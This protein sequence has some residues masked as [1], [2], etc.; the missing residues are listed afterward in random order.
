MTNAKHSWLAKR[1]SKNRLK[2]RQRKACQW[3]WVSIWPPSRET[4]TKLP[5]VKV[6]R[7]DQFPR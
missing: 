6:S 5:Q 4:S 3:V 7:A 1:N 2:P